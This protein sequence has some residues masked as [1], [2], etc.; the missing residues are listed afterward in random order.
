M[1][2]G[3]ILI[4]LIHEIGLLR[5]FCGEIR[6]VFAFAGRNNRKFEVEDSVVINFEFLNGAL[7]NFLLSD[8]AA[9]SKSWEMT[10]GENPAYPH[11]PQENC[12]HFAGTNGS[13]DFP[14][15]RARY[16]ASGSEPS[17][18]T[19]FEIDILSFVGRNPLQLQVD[20]FV[21]VVRGNA[22]PRVSAREGYMN[23]MVVE[24][25]MRSIDIGAA[26]ELEE[27]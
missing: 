11:F 16:Y 3:P 23:M 26:V 12:Y 6:R 25:I 9:S 4:N 24:A 13:L 20:H 19:P 21:E 5:Y 22:A 2:G 7:G 10:S 27:H 15:M 17:W 8:V 1:G 18:W 14:S